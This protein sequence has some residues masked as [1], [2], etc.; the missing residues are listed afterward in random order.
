MSW[1]HYLA[2]SLMFVNA[3]F[4]TFDGIRAFTVGDYLTP[5]SG[6]H[7]G[8]LGPWSKVVQAVGIEPRSNL[9][10][11]IHVALG[12]T[13]LALLGCF[14]MK[15]SWASNALLAA[16]FAG[17]WYLPVGTAL[18]AVAIVLLFWGRPQPTLS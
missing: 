7:S 13:T 6:P 14:L 5:K 1:Q 2:A 17:L 9:M 10:K 16:A 8:Q 12:V 3:A 18:N 11:G 4:M 15:F